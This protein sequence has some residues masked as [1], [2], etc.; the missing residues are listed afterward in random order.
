MLTLIELCNGRLVILGGHFGRSSDNIHAACR[1]HERSSHAGGRAG[2]TDEPPALGTIHHAIVVSVRPFG[3]FVELPGFRRNGEQST[4]SPCTFSR[5]ESL[6]TSN[7]LLPSRE[8]NFVKSSFNNCFSLKPSLSLCSGAGLVHNSQISEDVVFSREDDD[9]AKVQ[10]M[11]Y[12]APKGSQVMV[13]P[14]NQTQLEHWISGTLL[15]DPERCAEGSAGI[16]RVKEQQ[17]VSKA[18]L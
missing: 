4:L 6:A 7:S 13:F 16:V 8:R 14:E 2:I 3:L 18:Y 15:L 5:P 17:Q 12:F 1:R 11:E 10:A 9:E